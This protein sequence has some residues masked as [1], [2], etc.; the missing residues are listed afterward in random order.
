MSSLERTRLLE[1]LVYQQ[2]GSAVG[3]S[4]S[5]I[6]L[7]DQR[8]WGVLEN[9]FKELLQTADN[10]GSTSQTSAGEI[11]QA[12]DYSTIYMRAERGAVCNFA[13]PLAQIG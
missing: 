4:L 6:S 2:F 13:H 10:R 3:V 5:I 9:P 1:H 7:G 8:D 12:T 11:L